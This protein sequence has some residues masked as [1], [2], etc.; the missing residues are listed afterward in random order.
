MKKKKCSKGAKL[1]TPNTGNLKYE[2]PKL[3]TPNTSKLNYQTM[4]KHHNFI[5]GYHHTKDKNYYIF[6]Y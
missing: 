2:N 5:L 4:K 3:K 6:L 1:K